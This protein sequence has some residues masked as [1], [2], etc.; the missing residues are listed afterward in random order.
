MLTV[1]HVG[2]R[3]ISEATNK[4]SESAGCESFTQSQNFELAAQS[5]LRP[6]MYVLTPQQHLLCYDVDP[7]TR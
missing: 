7:D 1:P 5:E 3:C 6:Y 2:T 4:L